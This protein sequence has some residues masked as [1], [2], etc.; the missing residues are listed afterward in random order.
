MQRLSVEN[1]GEIANGT[2]Y[3]EKYGVVFLGTGRAQ[4]HENRR[5]ICM[6][7]KRQ[8]T[9]FS[10]AHLEMCALLSLDAKLQAFASTFF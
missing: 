5:V 1:L 3:G 4:W 8:T 10:R 2:H 7:L 9:D 6:H